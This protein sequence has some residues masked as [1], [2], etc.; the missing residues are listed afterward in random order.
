MERLPRDLD[1]Q[2]IYT[3]KWPDNVRLCQIDK[4]WAQIC[5]DKQIWRTLMK[6]DFPNYYKYIPKE[7]ST[8]EAY[9]QIWTLL[10]R[11]ADGLLK[12]YKWVNPRYA[13]FKL[14][15]E[16]IIQELI[17]DINENAK[18]KNIDDGHWEGLN[19]TIL[20]ILT[21]LLPSSI[22][23]GEDEI[24]LSVVLGIENTNEIQNLFYQLGYSKEGRKFTKS[25]ARK[26]LRIEP[27]SD[28]EF[29]SDESEGDEE[30]P[31]P[32]ERKPAKTELK[33][34]S[35]WLGN[36]ENDPESYEESESEEDSE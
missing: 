5:K 21:G 30:F 27:E 29:E 20:T 11:A 23:I 3:L 33:T 13:N 4:K 35:E 15:K 22:G 24:D 1:L 31:K 6:K 25:K 28:E 12:N 9:N 16:D 8:R 32:K 19:S 34:A 26:P 17:Y 36:E 2:L 10:N 14:M 7:Q 18:T